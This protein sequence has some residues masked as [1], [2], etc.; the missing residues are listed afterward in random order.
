MEIKRENTPIFQEI[1]HEKKNA[2]K[3]WAKNAND[4]TA[5]FAMPNKDKDK[6]KDK[7][8]D[9]S[10]C[11]DVDISDQSLMQ[12]QRRRQVLI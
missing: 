11:A 12:R 4:A 9:N 8:K 10:S 7:N 2:Y 3:R 6:D 5:F 1:S